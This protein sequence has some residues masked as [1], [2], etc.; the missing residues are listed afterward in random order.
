[1]QRKKLESSKCFDLMEKE[2]KGVPVSGDGIMTIL[3]L[4]INCKNKNCS[5]DETYNELLK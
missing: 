2:L 4:S 3:E 5:N 1:M